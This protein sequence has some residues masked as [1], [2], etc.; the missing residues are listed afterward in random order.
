MKHEAQV[1]LIDDDD[2]LVIMLAELLQL[3]GLCVARCSSG[4]AGLRYLAEQAPDVIVLDVMMPGMDGLET[5][6]RLRTFCDIPVLMLTGRGEADDRIRGLE[7]GA[8][9]YLAKPFNPRELLL[10]IRAILKRSSATG[11]DGE[12]QYHELTLDPAAMQAQLD[13]VPLSLTGAEL[14]VLE[15]LMRN[16]GQIATRETLTRAALGRKLSPYDRALDTHV[17]NLRQK[18]GGADSPVE[19]RSIRGSGYTLLSRS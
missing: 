8:D 17:S 15:T 6:Q 11:T 9:D 2:Q 3:E 18:L 13:G 4:E 5:L 16:A 14:K 19:I 10:R 12:L 7:L 1:L